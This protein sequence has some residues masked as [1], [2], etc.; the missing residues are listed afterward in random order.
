MVYYVI[1]FIERLLKLP[2]ILE[3]SYIGQR[4]KL[5]VDLRVS[6]STDSEINNFSSRVFVVVLFSIKKGTL[7]KRNVTQ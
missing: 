6:K 7:I 3:K 2:S 4:N 1:N 5:K